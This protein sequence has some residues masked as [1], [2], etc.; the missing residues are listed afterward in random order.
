MPMPKS[1][2]KINK[3]GV[4]FI[5]DVDRAEY[6]LQELTRAALKD[7][8]KML[9]YYGKKEA[10]KF[11]GEYKSN[12]ATWVRYDKKTNQIELQFGIYSTS[13]AKKKGKTP[14][15]FAH[16]IEF[17]SRYMPGINFLKTIVLDR[18][19]EIQ[20]IEGKYLS[21]IENESNIQSLIDESDEV[22]DEG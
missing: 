4:T 9:R 3:N 6:T 14:I 20:E 15:Y 8:A 11:S 19:K 5:S 18:L 22:N 13:T 1:V 2:T 7:V 21:A 17:G 16:I 10:P 12:I